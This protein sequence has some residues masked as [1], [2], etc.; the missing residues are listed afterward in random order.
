MDVHAPHQPLHTWKD[1]WIHLGTIT[2]G[3]LIAIAL[4]Q[5][6][7]KLHH[8][9]QRHQLEE[10]LRAEAAKNLVVMDENYRFIDASMA[11]ASA[12]RRDVDAIRASGGKIKLP[13]RP[14]NSPNANILTMPSSS[15]WTA[16]K[17]SELTVLLPREEAKMF[18]R[19]YNQLKTYE[20]VYARRTDVILDEWSLEARVSS[21]NPGPLRPDLSL[22]SSDQLDQLSAVLSRDLVVYRYLRTRM[23]MFYAAEKVVAEGGTTE[24]EALKALT[25]RA[26]AALP[27]PPPATAPQ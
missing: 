8:L 2:A 16:A 20:D 24:D 4:E 26:T 15:A 10:D 22:M 9:H 27:K 23:D 25:A 6:V 18:D 3:L 19:V 12:Y 11:W 1:F 17:E 21:V 14:F 7:E 5:S 13:F